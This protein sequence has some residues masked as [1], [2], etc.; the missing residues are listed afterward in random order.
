MKMSNDFVEAS[1]AKARR[2][3]SIVWR[4]WSSGRQRLQVD[5]QQEGKNFLF[6]AGDR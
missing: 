4:E 1:R 2:F 6:V 5:V 3:C